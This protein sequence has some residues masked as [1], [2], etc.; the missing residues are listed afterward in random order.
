MGDP[1]VD[2]S[3]FQKL[4]DNLESGGDEF[5]AYLWFVGEEDFVRDFAGFLEG[6][7]VA[8][9]LEVCKFFK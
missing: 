2:H 9:G 3:W 6:D 5:V 8:S 1:A 7:D 4:G